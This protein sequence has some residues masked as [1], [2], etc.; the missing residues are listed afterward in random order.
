[1]SS[2]EIE[3]RREPITSPVAAALIQA[4]NG[5]LSGRYP[6]AG[7]NHFRLDVEEVADGRGAFLVVYTGTVP[8]GCGAIR[9]LDAETA[10]IKRMYVDPSA[11]GQG[12]GRA[13]LASLESEARSLGVKRLVLETGARQP[14]AIA[15][16]AGAG[17]QRIPLFGEYLG[18]ALSVCMGKEI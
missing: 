11:R 8:V 14:E 15:L 5:E 18:S 6:E 3:V 1:M 16:Y 9:R 17:F 13:L 4:L 7:A 10:E 12:I 2:F